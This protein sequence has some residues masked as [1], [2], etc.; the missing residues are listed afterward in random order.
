MN[1]NV[2]KP[3]FILFKIEAKLEGF[4]WQLIAF[5]SF[6]AILSYHLFLFFFACDG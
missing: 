3:Y 5:F 1:R 6:I 2:K 4:S